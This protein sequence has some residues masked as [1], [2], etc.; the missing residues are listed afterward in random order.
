MNKSEL[1]NY[2]GSE[3]FYQDIDAA[4]ND[5]AEGRGLVVTDIDV[6]FA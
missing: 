4:Q 6:L 3:Q 1:R 5:I 2:F